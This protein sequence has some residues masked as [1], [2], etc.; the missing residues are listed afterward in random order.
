MSRRLAAA[1]ALLERFDTVH[2]HDIAAVAGVARSSLYYYFANKDEVL[3]FLLRAVLDDLAAATA[4][5]VE[6]D[7]DARHRL[8]AVV[9]AQLAHLDAHPPA[10]VALFANLAGAGRLSDIAARVDAGI[11]GPVRRLVADG[12][13]EGT[14]AHSIDPGVAA[15][16]LF[17]AVLVNGLRALVVHGRIDVDGLSS[18]LGAL[19][20]DGWSDRPAAAFG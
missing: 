8:G 3:G 1:G 5:A 16:A 15:I 11:E 9:R 17:G 10:V 12:V 20:W 7:G 19:F 13:A 14:F 2:M 6:V 4:S 18:A